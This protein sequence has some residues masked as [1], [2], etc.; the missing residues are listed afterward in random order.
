MSNL[1]LFNLSGNNI[2]QISS[3]SHQQ[4]P[5]HVTLI[6]AKNNLRT[7]ETNMFENLLRL[8]LLNLETND[9]E[10][11]LQNHNLTEPFDKGTYQ[12]TNGQ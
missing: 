6:I 8:Q 11:D 9:M 7:L 4:L 2:Q 12:G 1:S 5:S 3:L 10:F